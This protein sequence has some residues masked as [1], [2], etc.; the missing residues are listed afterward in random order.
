MRD[1][2]VQKFLPY[3]YHS[4]PLI[5]VL[6][7][8][9]ILA[10]SYGMLTKNNLIFIIGLLFVIGGYLLVRRKLKHHIRNLQ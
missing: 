1:L 10:V 9:G 8:I 2:I 5:A 6:C 4:N 7:S 3:L